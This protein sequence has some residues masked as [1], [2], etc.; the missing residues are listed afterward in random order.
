M[1]SSLLDQ[2]VFMNITIQ[3]LIQDAET[4]LQMLMEQGETDVNDVTIIGHSEGSIIAPRIAQANPQIKKMILLGA[5]AHN[6]RD[7]LEYQIVD[8]KVAYLDEVIDG[9]NDGLISINEVVSLGDSD[10]FLP[11]PDFTLIENR[12]GEWQWPIGIDSNDDGLMS[13]N[14]EYAPRNLSYLNMVTSPDYPLF[15]WIKS[16]YELETTLD[17]I[18]NV[19]CS[20]LILNGEA[21]VQAPVQEVFLLEQRL[22]QVNHQ[23][24]TLYTY[25]GLGHSFYPV[26]GWKQPLGPIQACVLSDIFTWLND[27]AR[28]VQYLYTKQQSNQKIIDEV[29]IHLLGLDSELASTRSIVEDLYSD[30]LRHKNEIDELNNWNIELQNSLTSSRKLSYIALGLSLF[31]TVKSMHLS[32]KEGSI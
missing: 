31:C 10:I 8:R 13:I 19:S 1:N 20:I 6:L 14:E 9:N 7:L 15:K 26:D 27:P 16:H 32:P 5:A 24:H 25:L 30:S 11:V 21:D 12:T 28:K 23:D 29:Q 2:D 17:I 3:T 4:A 18:G 22:S